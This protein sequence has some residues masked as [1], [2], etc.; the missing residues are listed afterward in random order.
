MGRNLGVL[1]VGSL[2]TDFT[3]ETRANEQ[4]RMSSQAPTQSLTK[5]STFNPKHSPVFFSVNFVISVLKFRSSLSVCVL[6]RLQMR[7]ERERSEPGDERC[8]MGSQL[9]APVAT[10]T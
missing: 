7:Q 6:M 2:N 8:P 4:C 10:T 5:H 1:T 3:G 9:F